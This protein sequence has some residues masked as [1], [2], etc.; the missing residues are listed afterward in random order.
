MRISVRNVSLLSSR[1]YVFFC[2]S[3]ENMSLIKL[4]LNSLRYAWIYSICHVLSIYLCIWQIKWHNFVNS[5][6]N[7]YM[8]ILY[9][10]ITDKFYFAFFLIHGFRSMYNSILCK[11]DYYL[12]LIMRSRYLS[13][14]VW[15]IFLFYGS[16]IRMPLG[17]TQDMLGTM[18]HFF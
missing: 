12:I 14:I 1:K 16:S 17:A 10:T 7:N 2:K 15:V 11:W 6:S 8:T 9:Y 4:I 5:I 13:Y 18:K 3:I